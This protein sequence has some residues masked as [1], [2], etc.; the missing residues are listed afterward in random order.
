MNTETARK[1]MIDVLRGVA[2]IAV[3]FFHLNEAYPPLSDLYHRAVKWGWLGV[4]V[5]FVISGY[6]IAAAREKDGLISFWFRR[7]LRIFPPYWAS[8]VLVLGIVILRLVHTGT[9]DLTILPAD[10][11]ALIYTALA[12]TNP[13]SSVPGINWAYWSLGYELAFY[14]VMGVLVYRPAGLWVILFSALSLFVPAFPLDHWGLFGLG[15]ASHYFLRK[16][17]PAAALLALLCAAS[18]FVHLGLIQTLCGVFTTLLILFPPAWIA[19]PLFRPLAQ[20]GLFSYSLYLIHV[21]I[22]CY[23]LPHYFPITFSRE[24]GPSLVQDLLFLTVCLL[25]AYLFYRLIEKPSHAFARRITSRP[26]SPPAS[27]QHTR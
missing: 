3:V 27:P 25:S 1:V 4:P 11:S 9:N 23:F 2:A 8:I 22:G 21:P 26:I 10:A 24:L 20:A 16:N 14:L 13:A 19:L 5:F 18:C 7:L 15:V 17:H 6:C 12:L